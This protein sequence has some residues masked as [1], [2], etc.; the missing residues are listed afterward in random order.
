[1]SSERI[2]YRI[3]GLFKPKYGFSIP[4]K[5]KKKYSTRRELI[6]TLKQ[7]VIT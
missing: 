2:E 5:I 7:F 4:I 6:K 1:M 3:C